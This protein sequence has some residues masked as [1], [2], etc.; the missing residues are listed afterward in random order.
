M[1]ISLIVAR[2]SNGVIGRDGDLPW[3][4]PADLA[5]FKRITMGHH[6]IMGRRTF[7]SLPGVLPGR[8]HVVLTRDRGY[9]PEGVTVVHS[10]DAALAIARGAGDDEAFVIGGGAVYREAITRADRV[11]LTDVHASVDGDVTFDSLEP[12]SWLETDRVRHEAD[13]RHAHAFSMCVY[14][15]RAAADA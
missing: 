4:L 7:A 2:A 3:R 10:L 14:D 8:P 5:H 12:T 15:R 1:R 9:A 13:D 6:L 11:Y